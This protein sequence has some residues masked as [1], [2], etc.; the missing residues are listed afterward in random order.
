MKSKTPYYVLIGIA[1]VLALLFLSACGSKDSV[2]AAAPGASGRP[3]AP[4]VVTSVQ[5]RD[6]PIQIQAI[7]NVE[8]Y[9]MVQIKSQLDGQIENIFFNQGQDVHKGQ[10]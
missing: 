4:V 5:Q 7:G 3:P 2:Q 1:L 9:Q 10:L 6:I 8:A